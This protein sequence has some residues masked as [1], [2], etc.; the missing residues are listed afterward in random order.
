MHYVVEPVDPGEIPG[1]AS[2]P[3]AGLRPAAVRVLGVLRD[4]DAWLDHQQI[5]DQLAATGIPLKKRTILDAG[6]ALVE[7]G[8]ALESGGDNGTRKTFRAVAQ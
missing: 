4:T 1:A 3:L 6:A 5:G 8:F 2:G 7:A